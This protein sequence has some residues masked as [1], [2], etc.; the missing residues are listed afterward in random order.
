MKWKSTPEDEERLRKAIDDLLY[1]AESR[2]FPQTPSLRELVVS[3]LDSWGAARALP[4]KDQQ[5]SCYP[6][7]DPGVHGFAVCSSDC[8]SCHSCGRLRPEFRVKEVE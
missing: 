2:M 7:C 6:E 3:V 1:A 5:G 8:R 4:M